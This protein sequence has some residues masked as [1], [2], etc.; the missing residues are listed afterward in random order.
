MMWLVALMEHNSYN[1]SD[2]TLLFVSEQDPH[3]AVEL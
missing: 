3:A 1:I 2:D